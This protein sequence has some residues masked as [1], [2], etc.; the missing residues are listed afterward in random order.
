M[1]LKNEI[2]QNKDFKKNLVK[3]VY[4]TLRF[5]IHSTS[6]YKNCNIRSSFLLLNFLNCLAVYFFS[7]TSTRNNMKSYDFCFVKLRNNFA[8]IR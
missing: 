6:S 7:Q 2:N 5:V 1:A 4:N 3:S 8:K